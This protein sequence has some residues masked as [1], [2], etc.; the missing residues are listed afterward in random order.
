MFHILTDS[1]SSKTKQKLQRFQTQLNT[2][3]PCEIFLHYVEQSVFEGL[4]KWGFER[5]QNYLTYYRLLLERFLPKDLDKCLYLD[6]DM[7]VVGDLR[8]LF[9]IDLGDNFAGVVLDSVHIKRHIIPSK[10][11]QYQDIVLNPNWQFNGGFILINLQAWRSGKIEQKA[12]EFLQNY[13]PVFLDQDTLNVLFGEN[14]LKLGLE[15]NFVAFSAFENAIFKGENKEYTIRYTRAEH[16]N[17]LKNLK[18]IHYNTGSKPWK[19]LI[20]KKKC[21]Q[22]LHNE[23]ICKWWKYALQTP[24]FGLDIK[25]L[26]FKLMLAKH[27]LRLARSTKRALKKVKNLMRH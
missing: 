16:E 18:I 12:L 2:I 24:I 4:N 8:E 6:V 10:N 1:L 22:N 27:P 7:L 5:K 14:T 19:S 9:T 13:N 15:W 21:K 20:K 26:R 17:A 25:I 11:P 3:Y 23:R